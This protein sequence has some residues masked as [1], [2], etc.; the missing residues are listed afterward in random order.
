MQKEFCVLTEKLK[1]TGMSC[2]NCTRAVTKTL[3]A[4]YGVEDAIVWLSNNAAFIRKD[5]RITSLEQLESALKEAGYAAV[6]LEDA[7]EH[8]LSWLGFCSAQWME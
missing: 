7:E 3:K 1:V 8:H 4:V 6:Q 2:G 5:E